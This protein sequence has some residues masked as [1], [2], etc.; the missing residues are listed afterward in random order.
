MT[1]SKSAIED[2]VKQEKLFYEVLS[3]G[4]LY[5]SLKSFLVP[6]FPRLQRT[7]TSE[8]S[9]CSSESQSPRR[10][11]LMSQREAQRAE[12]RRRLRRMRPAYVPSEFP[13]IAT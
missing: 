1:R 5:S 4:I 11:F 10:P 2:S 13:E 3:G 6:R 12:I 7:F 9:T 8:D